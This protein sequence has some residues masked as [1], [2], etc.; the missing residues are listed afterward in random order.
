MTHGILP[1]RRGFPS[2]VALHGK[3][4]HF[5]S[6]KLVWS[7]FWRLDNAN[8]LPARI[9]QQQIFHYTLM[10]LI[11]LISSN[12]LNTLLEKAYERDNYFCEPNVRYKYEHFLWKLLQTSKQF[13]PFT[14]WENPFTV[15]SELNFQHD[16]T[17]LGILC[18]T[19]L[20]FYLSSIP[21]SFW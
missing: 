8:E 21:T 20:P 16:R 6:L 19:P 12:C 5:I 9:P 2:K 11:N 18:E 14:P 1:S 4:C 3:T 17:V 10:M 7:W 15:G 13:F